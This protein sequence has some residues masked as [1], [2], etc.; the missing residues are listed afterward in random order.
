M[1]TDGGG[2]SGAN[3]PPEG[4]LAGQALAVAEEAAPAVVEVTVELPPDPN[5]CEPMRL[6]EYVKMA[7]LLAADL[8][9]PAK[10]KAKVVLEQQSLL[11][12]L[13]VRIKR[14][15][16]ALLPFATQALVMSNARMCLRASGRPDEPAGGIWINQVATTHLSPS[17]SLFFDACDAYGRKRTQ[18]HMEAAFARMQEGKKLA[19][20]KAA[21]V[22]AGGK[23]H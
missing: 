2:G 22:E 19:S 13:V 21:H 15:E 3:G 11:E 10:D 4:L 6:D 23:I 12:F 18:D 5:Y 7:L 14:L 9:D 1:N 16:A 20:E 8:N 17:E